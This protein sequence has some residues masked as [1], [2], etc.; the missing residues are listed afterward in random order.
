MGKWAVSKIEVQGYTASDTA[1]DPSKV[2][3]T[4]TGLS[5]DY[6]DFK[7]DDDDQVE[8]SIKGNRTI[9]TYVTTSDIINLSLSEGGFYGTVNN[10]TTNVLQFTAKL[11]KTSVIKTFYLTR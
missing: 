7:A 5:G 3:G 4:I 6:I 9:G 11:D 8:L 10:L 1:G 2:N